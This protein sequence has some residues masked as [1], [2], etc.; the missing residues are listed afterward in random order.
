M[1]DSNKVVMSQVSADGIGHQIGS[2]TIKEV[3][4]GLKFIPDLRDLVPGEHG[5]HVHE[6]PSCEAGD[7]NGVMVA[8]L[9]AGGHYDP[10]S[11][12]LHAGPEGNGHLGDLPVL[13]VD[14]KGFART[15]VISKRLTMADMHGRS[16]MIHAGGDNYSD[17][18]PM[19]GGGSRVACGVVK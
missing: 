2:I 8:A 10:D 15:A 3:A 18:P 19:G 14:E 11:T 6:Y 17:H 4:G 16:L 13:M 7:K 9:K 5:F 12:G 1:P